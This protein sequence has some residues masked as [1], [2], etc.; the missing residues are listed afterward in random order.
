MRGQDYQNQQ[1]M[2]Q[3]DQG[4]NKSIYDTT[5]NQNQ[6]Q[7]NSALGLLGTGNTYSGQDAA[8]ATT[9]QNAPLN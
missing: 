4:F 6:Q 1:Q 9:I 8:N 3:W 7:L 2:Y 5:F